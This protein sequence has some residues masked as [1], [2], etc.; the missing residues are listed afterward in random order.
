MQ[1]N[2]LV[3]IHQKVCLC[4]KGCCQECEKTAHRKK[5]VFVII[6]NKGFVFGIHKEVLF[7]SIM[8]ASQ[9]KWGQRVWIA[10]F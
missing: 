9:W 2:R 8:T 6:F 3:G 4:I 5:K 10:F 7:N 1:E